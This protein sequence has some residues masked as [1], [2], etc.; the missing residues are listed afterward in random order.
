MTEQ[1]QQ[2]MEEVD[3]PFVCGRC[4]ET[5]E[6]LNTSDHTP[7]WNPSGPNFDSYPTLSQM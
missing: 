2:R 4:K 5:A 3:D 1:E 7:A 6:Q